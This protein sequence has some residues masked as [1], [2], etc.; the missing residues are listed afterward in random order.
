[1]IRNLDLSFNQFS[2]SIPD[3]MGNLTSLV[4][5]AES[6]VVM[7]WIANVVVCQQGSVLSCDVGRPGKVVASSS[8]DQGPRFVVQP[9]ER[10]HPRLD[11]EPDVTTVRCGMLCH[12]SVDANVVC[13]GNL[14]AASRGV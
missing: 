13:A 2:G 8:R 4:Y 14:K 12:D 11:L 6:C 9:V 7:A 3:S 1:M 5:V 10:Q